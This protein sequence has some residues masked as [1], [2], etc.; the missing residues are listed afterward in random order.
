MTPRISLITAV[1]AASLVVAVPAAFGDGWG[2]DRQD[3]ASVVG[4]PD[5]FDR[6]VAA[7]QNELAAMLD[8][9]ERSLV[10]QRGDVSTPMLEGRELAFGAKLQAQLAGATSPDV[11]DRAVAARIT[12]TERPIVG[13][14]GDRFRIDPTSEPGTVAAVASSDDIE[15]PQI[16]FGVLLGLAFALGVIVVLRTTRGRQLA[17]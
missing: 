10:T 9:R 17:H 2:A 12:E 3:G 5:L 16:G 7:R 4:S 15:W 13:D 6:A 8:A 11:F 14:G 1:A